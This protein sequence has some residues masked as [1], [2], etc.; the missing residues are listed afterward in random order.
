[1]A[2]IEVS[3]INIFQVGLRRGTRNQCH[4]VSCDDKAIF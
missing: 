3:D 4:A 2:K 1:M